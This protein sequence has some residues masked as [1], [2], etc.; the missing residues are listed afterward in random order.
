[1]NQCTSGVVLVSKPS[2]DSCLA[3]PEAWQRQAVLGGQA[4]QRPRGSL[5][6]SL[7]ADRFRWYSV[8][9]PIR[10]Q[11]QRHRALLPHPI[12]FPFRLRSRSNSHIRRFVFP[13]EAYLCSLLLSLPWI[14]GRHRLQ[15]CLLLFMAARSHGRHNCPTKTNLTQERAKMPR[16]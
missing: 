9:P 3:A 12:P 15:S 6:S 2:A 1:M 8:H 11:A 7:A 10:H 5:M 13:L 14:S 16:F 4:S